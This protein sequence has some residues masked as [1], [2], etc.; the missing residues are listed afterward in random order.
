[1]C[2]C[3][4][5]FPRCMMVII[6]ILTCKSN[7]PF[8][9]NKSRPPYG[10]SCRHVTRLLIVVVV[11]VVPPPPPP[12]HV[13]HLTV[14]PTRYSHDT[15]SLDRASHAHDVRLRHGLHTFDEPLVVPAS[16]AHQ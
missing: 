12:P 13:S 7:N 15:E 4:T 11:V 1:M 5:M 10:T 2:V 3:V 6:T 9:Q 14:H 8:T 16:T